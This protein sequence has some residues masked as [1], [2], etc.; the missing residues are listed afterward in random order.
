MSFNS[1]QSVL[2]NGLL[3]EKI[4][5]QNGSENTPSLNESTRNTLSQGSGQ[6]Y[7]HFEYEKWSFLKWSEKGS[8]F[9]E[10]L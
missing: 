2:A 1:G 9:N 3:K 10:G 7:F 4:S 6:N 5:F 8:F